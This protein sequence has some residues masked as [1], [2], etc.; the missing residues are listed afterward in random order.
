[1]P[2]VNA[3]LS[4][5]QLCFLNILSCLKKRNK[6]KQNK[7]KT[8]QSKAKQNKTKQNKTKQN[9][10]KQKQSKARQN[11]TKKKQNKNQ[12]KLTTQPIVHFRKMLIRYN[13][14]FK[15]YTYFNNSINQIQIRC[16]ETI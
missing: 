12:T 9:K 11:K 5:K 2:C 3:K 14:L 6:T 16:G 10:T 1:M 8:T 15:K 4:V 7:T 13:L